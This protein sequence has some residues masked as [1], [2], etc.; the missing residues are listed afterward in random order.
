[1][2]FRRRVALVGDGFDQDAFRIDPWEVEL[3]G[4]ADNPLGRGPLQLGIWYVGAFPT[5]IDAAKP[6]PPPA[7]EAVSDVR[8]E[9]CYQFLRR[10]IDF[11]RQARS[12]AGERLQIADLD[13]E[14]PD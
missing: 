2:L 7:G 11:V 9:Q 10:P 5:P 14:S 3:L 12:A 8:T 4:Q 1:M 6:C 13:Q